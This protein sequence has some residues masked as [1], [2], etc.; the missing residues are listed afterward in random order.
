MRLSEQAA[1]RTE[2]LAALPEVLVRVLHPLV[3]LLAEAGGE[4]VCAGELV[5]LVLRLERGEWNGSVASDG[6]LG[7]QGDTAQLGGWHLSGE[8]Q[9]R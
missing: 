3:Q 8:H 9:A 7:W 2:G 6:R 1:P 5:V 4:R